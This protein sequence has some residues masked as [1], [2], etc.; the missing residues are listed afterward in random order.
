[1]SE[2]IK[3]VILNTI[4]GLVFCIAVTL[5]LFEISRRNKLCES[6]SDD[7]ATIKEAGEYEH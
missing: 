5:L 7:Y 1:M 3:Q 4:A 6:Y 2:S